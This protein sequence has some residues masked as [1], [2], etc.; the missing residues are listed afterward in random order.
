MVEKSSQSSLLEANRNRT[1]FSGHGK[2]LGAAG[3]KEA[4]DHPA[5]CEFLSEPGHFIAISPGPDGLQPFRIG[6]TWDNSRLQRGNFFERLAKRLLN[7]GIDLDLGCL[8]ELQDG[9]R[10]ALQAFGNK[11]GRFDAPPFIALSSDERTGNKAG[12]DEFLMVNGPHWATIKR[13]LIYIYI[14]DG[15]NRWSKI[16]PQIVVDV[17][18]ENDLYVTLKA[19]NDRLALCAVA[20]LE[21]VRGGI[22]LINH[23]EYFPGHQEMDRAFGFG[24][25]W[26]DGTKD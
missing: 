5:N 11:H 7:K 26:V 23:T 6:V 15:S 21:N 14:Y 22:K 18:G 17:P 10:G 13:M 12:H 24:L 16:K 19:T 20:G 1:K 4:S 25:P 8:Y 3:Y 2:A 9:T